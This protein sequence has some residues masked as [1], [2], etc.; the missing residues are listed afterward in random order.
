MP[1][2][3]LTI[4]LAGTLS[5]CGVAPQ[6]PA[7]PLADPASV[8]SAP[9][10]ATAAADTPAG[11]W[12][13]RTL[14][15]TTANAVSRALGAN[16]AL[17][18]AQ[19]DVAAARAAL[20]Q[21]E[22][23]AG[24]VLAADADAGVQKSASER[25]TNSR[26]IGIGAELPLDINGAISANVDAAR[27]TLESTIADADQLRSD[28]ARDLMLAVIDGAEARQRQ[29]LLIAQTDLASRLL[30]LIELRFTQ[31]LAS[32]VDVLQQRDQLASLRQQMPLATL[33][34]QTA[35]NRIRRIAGLVTIADKDL[36]LAQL[37]ALAEEF[38]TVEPTALLTRRPALRAAKARIAAADARFA[39][40]LADRWPSLSLS[41]AG[42][43]RVL[44]GDATTLISAALDASLTL[45]DSG[46]KVAIAEQRRAELLAAG[47]QLLDDWIN[48]VIAADDL[49]LTEASLRQRIALSG[50]RLE[51]AQALLDAAQ[52]RF[53]RGVSD[54]LPVLEALRGLQQQ[55]RDHVV[56]EADLARARVRLHHALG[57]RVDTEDA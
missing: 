16:V 19:A 52:R 32:S 54:Y 9:Y 6:R 46:R 51:T 44:A 26:S 39:N 13:H 50:Q 47:E 11:P 40:A 57:D 27:A 8:F 29:V 12:W 31:G 1:R 23:A 17:R 25:R 5:A 34:A 15:V 37:P 43:T 45:F 14:D 56:L 18:R 22:A 20:R 4:A 7:P 38:A 53:E 2:R 30:R 35:D 55:Q 33:D 49:L 24:P 48:S 3:L 28:F 10:P 41:A 36:V 21:A 42:V